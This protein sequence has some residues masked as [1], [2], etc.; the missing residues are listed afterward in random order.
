MAEQGDLGAGEQANH[1]TWGAPWPTKPGMPASGRGGVCALGSRQTCALP[2]STLHPCSGPRGTCTPGPAPCGPQPHLRAPQRRLLRRARGR[3]R[4]F[5]EVRVLQHRAGVH[6]ALQFS[7]T[8]R[9]TLVSG[10]RGSDRLRGSTAGGR[11]LPAVSERC[12]GAG[13]SG[14]EGCNRGG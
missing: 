1:T 5:V 2:P 9:C 4:V 12:S 13:A 3:C 10:A 14:M 7:S 6:K 8:L 11:G